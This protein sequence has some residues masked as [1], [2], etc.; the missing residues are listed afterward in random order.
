MA[1]SSQE[2]ENRYFSA[3]LKFDPKRD[4]IWKAVTENIQS[5]FIDLNDTIIDLGCGYGDFINHAVVKKKIAVDLEDVKS[6]LH[7]DIEFHRT[8]VENLDFLDS[9][10]VNVVFGSNL[11]EHLDSK[12][13]RNTLLEIK[14]IL[15]PSGK[16]ILIQ[17]NFR[18][19][20]KN[21]FDD[22]THQTIFTDESLCGLL[23]SHDFSVMYKKAGYLPFSM[24]S[25]LPKSYWLTRAYLAL[26]SPLMSKQ[27][28]IVGMK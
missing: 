1:Q 4:L 24:Q 27:M 2:S 9:D 26:G 22:Y 21:Y 12:Q 28:L 19:C 7:D 15:K 13:I 17:P 6:Y 18:L 23:M 5:R 11:L 8:S 25:R 14:R 20:Y 10:S 3:R 16:I